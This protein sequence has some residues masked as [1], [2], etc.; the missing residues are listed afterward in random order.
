M[1][2]SAKRMREP[3]TRSLTVLETSNS[4]GLAVAATRDPMCRAT[5]DLG[6]RHFDLPSMQTSADLDTELVPC[7]NNVQSAMNRAS[8]SIEG[9]EEPI[10]GGINLA[11]SKPSELSPNHGVML[12][13]KLYP[14]TIAETVS[15]L[16]RAGNVR[17]KQG[18]EDMV[19]L[20]SWQQK[21]SIL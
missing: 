2:Q 15:E 3:A 18:R 4:P 10:T 19:R 8:R 12:L 9:G 11:A 1:P 5:A 13:E 7:F 17:E 21:P 6:A 14:G 20:W 16:C